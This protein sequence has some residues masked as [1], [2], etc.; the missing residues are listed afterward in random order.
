MTFLALF[1]FANLKVSLDLFGYVDAKTGDYQY[2][3]KP[4]VIGNFKFQ[5]FRGYFDTGYPI[6]G[7]KLTSKG[8]LKIYQAY[9]KF[10]GNYWE[11]KLGKILFIPGFQGLFNPFRR[12]FNFETIATSL[13]GEQGLFLRASTPVVTSLAF[14]TLD[15]SL[16]NPE[17]TFQVTKSIGSFDLGLY[18]N[19]SEVK[20]L[21]PGIF[22]GY[23]GKFTLKAQLVKLDNTFKSFVQLE[24]KSYKLLPSAWFF[25]SGSREI[26]P[27]PGFPIL[28]GKILA[29]ELKFPEKIFEVPYILIL[30][31][32]DNRSLISLFDIR[33]PI[34]NTLSVESGITLF[35]NSQQIRTFIYGGLKMVKGF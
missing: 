32:I 1:F 13:E 23:Y 34:K 16:K 18:S 31:D 26:L 28:T 27:T 5:N 22:A 30:C 11:S 29:L 21:T 24:F 20:G 19:Y 17:I 35:K 7:G 33:F 9:V 25:Y 3:L 4:E 6:T 8:E 14:I 15:K 10:Q 12:S 2:L